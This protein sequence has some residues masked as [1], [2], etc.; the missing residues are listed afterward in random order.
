MM[1]ATNGNTLLGFQYQAPLRHLVNNRVG[2]TF[3]AVRV[4]DAQRKKMTRKPTHS[5]KQYA[6]PGRESCATNPTNL[7]NPT[8]LTPSDAG[9]GRGTRT[10]KLTDLTEPLHTHPHVKVGK[11]ETTTTAT[12]TTSRHPIG[13]LF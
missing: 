7:L 3:S 8:A 4:V 12:T 6:D 11:K 9:S 13:A 2:E 10:S 5:E 1:H